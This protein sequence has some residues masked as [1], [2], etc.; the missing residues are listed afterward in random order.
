MLSLCDSMSDFFLFSAL[1][2]LRSMII[3]YSLCCLIYCS[4][5]AAMRSTCAYL[6]STDSAS[7][8]SSSYDSPSASLSLSESSSSESVLS[9]TLSKP[10]S[11][12]LSQSF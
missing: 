12:T 6:E 11:R 2:V 10:F 8:P 1:A 7:L 4:N 3:A 5:S 9:P